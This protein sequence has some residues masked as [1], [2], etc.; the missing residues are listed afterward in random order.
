[1]LKNQYLYGIIIKQL[2]LGDDKLNFKL[3]FE[4]AKEK[5]KKT[6]LELEGNWRKLC[7]KVKRWLKQKVQSYERRKGYRER[8]LWCDENL[9]CH[10]YQNLSKKKRFW[11]IPRCEDISSSR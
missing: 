11:Q 3:K 7:Y 2:M 8:C 9:F 5:L 6:C 10:S 1:M 4:K